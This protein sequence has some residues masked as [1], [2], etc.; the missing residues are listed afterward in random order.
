MIKAI[1]LLLSCLYFSQ[2]TYHFPFM[3]YHR[4]Y[5]REKNKVFFIC[6]DC[7]MYSK[8]FKTADC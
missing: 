7:Y 5:L 4:E 3:H 1:T 8:L 2:S 6:K